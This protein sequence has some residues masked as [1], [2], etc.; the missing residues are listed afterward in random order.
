MITKTTKYGKGY[1]TP[2]GLTE[3]K[4]YELMYELIDLVKLKGLTVRQA[5]KLFVDCS[6]VIL[7]IK[8]NEEHYDNAY[9]KSISESLNKIANQGID[10]YSRCSSTNN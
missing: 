8:L 1:E 6:D 7:D 3:D 2:I 4:Y 5:Q 9:L 10:T